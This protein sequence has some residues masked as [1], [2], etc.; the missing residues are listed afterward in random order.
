VR[1]RGEMLG[2]EVERGKNEDTVYCTVSTGEHGYLRM[3]NKSTSLKQ[4]FT[5]LGVSI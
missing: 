3:L 1:Q 4:S 5:E 2:L